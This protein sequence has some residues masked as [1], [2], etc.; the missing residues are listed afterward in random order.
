MP[1]QAPII[2]AVVAVIIIAAGAY[3]VLGKK[4]QTPQTTST[5][6]ATEQKSEDSGS[7]KG[8]IKSLLGSNKNVMCI[9]KPEVDQTA[10]QKVY[11]SGNKMRGDFTMNVEGKQFESHMITDGTSAYT[12]SSA[13]PQG[14]K[15]KM[16]ESFVSASP[17]AGQPQ[18]VDIDKQ[19]DM[20]CSPW[21]V[22]ESLFNLPS[23]IKF[24]DVSSMMKPAASSASNQTQQNQGSS[25]CDSITDP[26][27]KAACKNAGY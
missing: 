20:Q 22:D 13:M 9:I 11:I 1:K 19:I 10:E 27:A 7:I 18:Q 23:D 16:D 14:I 2:I 4:S 26:E 5:N 21:N 6:T 25:V 12:W 15:M 24:L 3:L 8:S 17:V